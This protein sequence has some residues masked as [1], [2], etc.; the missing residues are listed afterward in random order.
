MDDVDAVPLEQ[1]AQSVHGAGTLAGP[2]YHGGPAYPGNVDQRDTAFHRD[3]FLIHGLKALEEH[4]IHR[5]HGAAAPLSAMGLGECGHLEL[6]KQ[7]AIDSP[8]SASAALAG[9]A[10]KGSKLPRASHG[11]QRWLAIL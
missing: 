11:G 8:S 3:Q 10:V 5:P 6:R 9:H 1:R 2:Q 4:R 7:Q